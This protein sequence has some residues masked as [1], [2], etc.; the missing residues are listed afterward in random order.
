MN[1][2]TGIASGSKRKI[3]DDN[4]SQKNPR[5]TEDTKF[6][7]I[8][9]TARVKPTAE[10]LAQPRTMALIYYPNEPLGYRFRLRAISVVE[11]WNSVLKK[12]GILNYPL[13]DSMRLN[14]YVKKHTS[15]DFFLIFATLREYFIYSHVNG[16]EQF[17]WV[18]CSMHF[19][20][21]H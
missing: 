13:S 15:D 20:L 14:G 21:W 1:E 12:S 5:N 3:K 16:I 4:V 11:N 9:K 8:R 2:G 19:V 10:K 17:L 7:V 18:T 6:P